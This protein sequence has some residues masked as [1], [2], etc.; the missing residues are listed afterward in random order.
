M[1][2]FYPLIARAVERL[3]EH[4]PE[5]RRAVY[6]RARSALIGQLRALD[7]PS[8]ETE[9]ARLQQALEDAISRVE[10]R[11]S[12]PTPAPQPPPIAIP[13]RTQPPNTD[14]QP[15]EAAQGLGTAPKPLEQRLP[16]REYPLTKLR[17]QDT[18]TRQKRLGIGVLMILVV[19]TGAA[20][21]LLRSTSLDRPS[22]PPTAEQQSATEVDHAAVSGGHVDIEQPRAPFPSLA[23]QTPTTPTDAVA[24]AP[25]GVPSSPEPQQLSGSPPSPPGALAEEAPDTTP[26]GSLTEQAAA[27][28]ERSPTTA[29]IPELPSLPPVPEPAPVDGASP[30][31][32]A[33]PAPG[34]TSPSAM[35]AAQRAVLYEEN[36]ADSE[37]PR[38]I[39]GS[40][41]WRLE[42]PPS[43]QGQ[44]TETA[45]RSV[46]EVPEAGLRL[47]L[48]I[49]RNLDPTLPAS[50]IIELT[51]TTPNEPGRSVR[52]VGLPQLKTDEAGRGTPLFGLPVPVKE[53]V[54]LVGL[55]NVPR[56]IDSNTDLFLQRN[57]IDLPIHFASG[58]RAILMI[59]MGTLGKR[60]LQDAFH[61]WSPQPARSAA[62]EPSPD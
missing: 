16:S 60:V 36:K 45:V 35:E 37:S 10:A 6:E 61:Q 14:L 8:S 44:S 40:T 33:D 27:D 25:A 19:G 30:Q 59:E 15:P 20:V 24:Q 3:P 48:V 28:A 22:P 47:H 32:Q 12:A 55:S 29:D 21:Y 13:D 5:R 11:Y 2:D 51:F 18:S 7:P 56:D 38:A 9:F 46:T 43:G 50:H 62:R 31:P 39:P 42:T 53:N 23:E 1:A 58:L 4:S 34:T 52:D 49:R 41:V 57:W 26:T 54:F 17:T